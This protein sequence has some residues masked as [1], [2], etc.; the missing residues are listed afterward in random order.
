MI[1]EQFWL[2]VEVLVV[3]RRQALEEPQHLHEAEVVLQLWQV[4][5]VAQR[6]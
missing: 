1:L 4:L 5:K 2:Q 6:E 3:V